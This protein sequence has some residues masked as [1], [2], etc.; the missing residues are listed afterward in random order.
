[1]NSNRRSRSSVRTGITSVAIF[2][3]MIFGFFSSAMAQTPTMVALS[4]HTPKAVLEGKAKAVGPYNPDQMLRLVI[5]LKHPKAAEEEQFLR[6]V[7]TKDSPLFHK[8][9]TAEEWNGRFAPSAQD[10]KAVVDWARAQ[11]L[12]LTQRYPNR[13]LVDVQA[14]VSTIQQAFNIEIKAYT[15]GTESYFSNDRAPAIPAHLANIIHSVG[16]LNSFEVFHPHHT[17]MKQIAYPIYSPGPAV[18]APVSDHHDAGKAPTKGITPNITNGFYDPSD[19]Y[20]SE[21]YNTGA[22]DRQGHCCNPF[23][24]GGGS[25]PATSIAIPSVGAQSFNDMNGFATQYPYLAYNINELGINGQPVP[26]TSGCDLEGTMDMQ[27]ST[28]MA[29]SHGSFLDTAHVWMYDG[30]NAFLSTFTDLFNHML[31]DG[32]AR[33]MSTSWGCGE[34]D[35]ASGALMDTQSGIFSSM[36][37]QGWT[38][39]AASDDQGATASCVS[40][41]AVEFPASDPRVV[42]VGGTTLQLF[43]NGT[44]FSEIGWVG[45]TAAGSC[46]ANN[47]GSGG[48]FSAKFG[49][50]A[51]QTSMGFGS[52]AVPDLSLNANIGQNIFFNG[53]LRGSGGT[54]IGAPEIAGFYA[55]SNAYLLSLGN[56]CGA[57]GVNPCSPQGDPHNSI[58]N[59]GKNNGQPHHPF[60]DIT[61][62]CNSNDITAAFALPFFCAGAGFDEVT[63]WGTVNFLQLAWANNWW[64]A[65]ES[66][67]PIVT[68]SGPTVNQWYNTDQF[69][70]YTV[71]DTGGSFTPTGV[72]GFTQGW[73][74]IP[75]DPFSQSTPGSGNSFYSGPQFPN[76]TSGCLSLGGGFGCAGGVAQGMHVAHVQ[77]WDNM[78]LTSF[79]V[80]YGPIGYDTIPPVTVGSLDTTITPVHVTLIASDNA[81]GVANTVYQ[82]DGGPVKNYAGPFTVTAT[83]SHTVNFHSTD[84]ATNVEANQAIGWTETAATSTALASSLNPSPYSKAVTFTATVTSATPGA[85]TGTVTF[86]DGAT[87]LSTKTL[88]G[89]K[90]AF[91]TPSLT[92]GSHAITATYN[93]N[94]TYNASTGALTQKVIKASTAT[95]L[96]SSIHPSVFGQAVTFTATVTSATPGVSGSVQFFDGGALLHTSSLLGG[97]ETFTTT[98]LAA[99]SHS[100]TAS[101]VGNTNFTASTSAAVSQTVNK[102]STKTTMTSSVNPTV[103]GQLVKFTATVAVVAP[104]MGTPTGTVTFRDGAAVL[105]TIALS[106]GK[107][108]LSTSALTVGAHSIT[109]TYNVSANFNTSSSGALTQT[110]NKAATTAKVTSSKNP[111]ALNQAVTFTVTVTVTAPGT[112]TP[113]GSVTL[114]DGPA[115]LGTG[116]LSGGK[117]TFTTSLLA[118]GTHSISAIYAGSASDAGA[119]SPVLTQTVN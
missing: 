97:K 10:E 115:T 47:G 76:S 12:T 108:S 49:T 45:G 85:I 68:F 30:P 90:A 99:G 25:P 28:A 6:D 87:V 59:S 39:V 70:S 11:G 80:T 17:N 57:F 106:S 78:G 43:S 53:S 95:T 58:Y 36:I 100:I 1:M 34:F 4:E 54:S 37:G 114:K 13:L 8:F 109:A 74:G 116:T 46:A 15:L 2:L 117:A 52:R 19:I 7:Q 82:L 40:H 110:V 50:P 73:D 44:Y 5:G 94:A 18:S 93:G 67:R 62:G 101:F 26:C 118:H 61:S 84:V 77:A 81:S 112:G 89:G 105:G 35:C 20:S 88:S 14:K 31:A 48:G 64:N 63:G 65:A 32:V 66:G 9:L 22:L 21:A 96:T 113:T 98:G 103:S 38:L 75:G 27:W 55:Q 24:A 51:Y 92:G 79:D 3:V 71:V 56:I 104:G 16:G 83:G 107:A 72:A 102:A 41:D 29:N 91:T 33:V 119:T 69:V 111:S 86:M 23:H 60:Y 42:A